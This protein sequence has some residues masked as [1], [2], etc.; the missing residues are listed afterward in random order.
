[1]LSRKWW[2]FF[3]NRALYLAIQDTYQR[4][5][6]TV[7]TEVE[8]LKSRPSNVP[9]P[10]SPSVQVIGALQ[11]AQDPLILKTRRFVPDSLFMVARAKFRQYAEPSFSPGRPLPRALRI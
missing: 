9:S 7:A 5:V 10:S 8:I 1:M 3:G 4:L 11:N 6:V 2:D